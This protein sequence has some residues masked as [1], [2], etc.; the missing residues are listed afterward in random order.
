MKNISVLCLS[1][2]RV[3][4]S[5]RLEREREREKQSLNITLIGIKKYSQRSCI[6]GPVQV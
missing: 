1:G 5:T 2:A 6:G 3:N 4:S